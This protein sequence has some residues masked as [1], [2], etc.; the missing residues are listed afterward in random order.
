MGF[1]DL[2]KLKDSNNRIYLILV[3]WLL[4]GFIIIQLG[5]IESNIIPIIAIIIFLPFLA[6]TLF[7]F[8]ISLFSKKNIKE[9]SLKNLIIIFIISLPITSIIFLVLM[10][11][12]L[13]ASIISY[14]L[15]TSWFTIYGCYSISMKVDKKL[16]KYPSF[17][18]FARGT[19]FF[20]GLIGAL[21]LL[22]VFFVMSYY[23]STYTRI[24]PLFINLVYIVVA[25]AIIGL[26]I[27]GFSLL[28]RKILPAWLGIFF[29]LV[30]F[31]TFFLVLKV[32]LGLTTSGGDN[33]TP[34]SILIVMVFVDLIILLY[35]IGSIMGSQGELLSQKLN[36]KF[37][38]SV[39]VDTV[40]L[41]LI[42]TKAAYE[43]CVN[44]PYD[45][46]HLFEGPSIPLIITLGTELNLIKNIAVLILFIILIV[47]IGIYEIK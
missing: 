45:L 35:S 20:G 3:V 2:K 36:E 31:Y 41:W 29:I 37:K 42:F 40:L 34:I 14:I 44:F 1:S 30:A 47:I 19:E 39:D 27:I 6:F 26:A 9:Y 10:I 18:S 17:K 33:N 13:A 11:G 24:I 43:Y 38:I 23:F 15:I 12:L 7:L 22:F 25:I 16:Y 46:L 5:F 28:C 21:A 8:L 32:F 4:I